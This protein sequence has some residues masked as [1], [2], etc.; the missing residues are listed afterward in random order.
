MRQLRRR[1][2]HNCSD[3][4]LYG[5]PAASAL[6][7]A[8]EPRLSPP[9]VA[10]TG[11]RL[12]RHGT[13]W[14][15][16]ASAPCCRSVPAA[17]P[18]ALAARHGHDTSA[19]EIPAGAAP[20]PGQTP[21]DVELAVWSSGRRGGRPKPNTAADAG[22]GRRGLYRT[23]GA[24]PSNSMLAIARRRPIDRRE[25]RRILLPPNGRLGA[26][27][28]LGESHQPSGL[29]QPQAHLEAALSGGQLGVE[30]DRGT[31]LG[32]TDLDEIAD[33]VHGAQFGV[34]LVRHSK[35]LARGHSNARGPMRARF[36]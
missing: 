32:G 25:T 12:M 15:T 20:L 17:Q 1:R 24:R 29:P 33:L 36:R 14:R 19:P 35:A 26:D 11:Q 3:T 23:P 2:P 27:R 13:V 8:A 9:P 22:P 5:S 6:C 30:A 21:L 7:E 16:T 34:S 18:T 10:S 4:R 31:R 28:L